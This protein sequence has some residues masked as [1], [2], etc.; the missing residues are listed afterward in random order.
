M[1]APT[2]FQRAVKLHKSRQLSQAI[3]LYQEH[4]SATQDPAAEHYLGLALIQNRRPK[5]GLTHLR[6]ATEAAPDNALYWANL[7]KALLQS[8]DRDGARAAFETATTLNPQDAES[9]NNLAG[10]ERQSGALDRAI[11]AY[12]K[13][14]A[15]RDHP[16]IA[17]NLGLVAKD[18][19]DRSLARDAFKQVI[20]K[21]PKPIRALVQLASMATEDGAFDEAETLLLR[22]YDLDPTSARS[23]AALLTLRSYQPSSEI[24]GAA[25]RVLMSPGEE[26]EKIRL[27][28][29]LARA[30]Q[31]RE[32]HKKAWEFAAKA[33][34]RV[35]K[36]AP[37]SAA[38][39][40]A[41]LAVLKETFDQTLIDRLQS[42]GG[43][44][45]GLIFV[46]GLPRT[47]TTLVEQILSSHPDVFGADERPEIPAMVARLKTD[48]APYPKALKT[49]PIEMLT[50]AARR[51]ETDIQALAP[52]AQKV[53]DKLPF[54]FSHLGLIA[55]LFP[56]AQII[57]CQRDLRDVFVS[58]FFTE[59]TDRLQGF[60]T[61]AENF[62]IF[63][64]TYRAVMAHWQAVIP[65]R[66]FSVQYEALV[67]DFDS[68][69]PELLHACGLDWHE[70]CRT[71]F[72]TKRTVRTPSRWQVR[73]PLYT[74][75]IE[76]WRAY[77][78]FLGPVAALEASA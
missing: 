63:A 78:G 18:A 11:A 29:G 38:A 14:L 66:I 68:L 54:N 77:E 57:H 75:S 61:S 8:P 36:S 31:R 5:D 35:A 21:S 55:G 15:L 1:S 60:R 50:D 2:L 74:S 30:M 67:A 56:N 41:E 64:E 62:A 42:A 16:A 72:A 9:W 40:G 51:H 70:D 26:D 73:Q 4:L 44:G 28:F 13:A 25:E 19:G 47:G 27:G 20:E 3:A 24:L 45:T 48:A 71:F 49:L 52:D 43:D 22:A 34:Q 53:V 37:F 39:L 58:C 76:R 59:F 6:R 23:L 69:A 10:L 46:V 12:Q 33:N 17:L 7:G 65:E 32:A